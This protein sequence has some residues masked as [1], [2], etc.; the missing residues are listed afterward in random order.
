M[1]A[2]PAKEALELEIA[3]RNNKNAVDP[4]ACPFS[5]PPIGGAGIRWRDWKVVANRFPYVPAA[6]PI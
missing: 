3:E 4:E 1:R 5:G 6:T 2:R